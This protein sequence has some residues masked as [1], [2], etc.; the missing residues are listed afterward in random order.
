[1]DLSTEISNLKTQLMSKVSSCA[2]SGNTDGVIYNSKLIEELKEISKSYSYL[3]TKV[4][5][6]KESFTTESSPVVQRSH[7]RTA[8][9]ISA[10]AKG[11]ERRKIFIQRAEMKGITLNQIR[12]VRYNSKNHNLIGI[13]SAS[14]VTPNHWF[15]GLP[16]EQYDTVVLLCEN[17][18]GNVIT[19]IPPKDFIQKYFNHFSRDKKGQIKFNI[20]KKF[21]KYLM[22]IPDTDGF[23]VRYMIDNFENL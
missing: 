7:G 15:M 5:K 10:K 2:A 20:N 1:M 14:E 6:L 8:D 4:L 16:P 11:E 22:S 17:D 9:V 23:D 19:F 3:E 12:G 18:K 13:A 21:D